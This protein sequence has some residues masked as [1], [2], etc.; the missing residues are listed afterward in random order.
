MT[1]NGKIFLKEF[2]N[3]RSHNN[4]TSVSVNRLK[5]MCKGNTEYF[6]SQMVKG[7]Y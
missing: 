5:F 7:N 6:E 3:S 1:V 2:T 4:K